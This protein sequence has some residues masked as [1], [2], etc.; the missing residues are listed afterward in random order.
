MHYVRASSTTSQD[1]A[2][3][4]QCSEPGIPGT[5]IEIKLLFPPMRQQIMCIS[6]WWF[7]ATWRNGPAFFIVC[8][9]IPWDSV[10]P[11][12]NN[13]IQLL[14]SSCWPNNMARNTMSASANGAFDS[15][16]NWH[17]KLINV[18]TCLL[19]PSGMCQPSFSFIVS[20]GWV[21]TKPKKLHQG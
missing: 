21:R 13:D 12:N 3:I 1:I 15:K 4:H 9:R 16:S 17:L 20:G 14:L 5:K 18:P 2:V 10:Q 7:A 19:L 8:H 11:D 6:V